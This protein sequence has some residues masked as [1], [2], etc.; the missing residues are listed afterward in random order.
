MPTEMLQPVILGI[1]QGLGE[2][3][4]ISS[5]AHLILVPY[6]FNWSDPGLAFDVALHFG[7]LIAVLA[8][9]WK[10]W[11]A[12]FESA[13]QIKLSP[14]NL[15]LSSY[16]YSQSMPGFLIIT[17]LP[18][19]LA[20]YFL[21]SLAETRFRNPLLI[22]VTLALFGL[23]LYLIDKY[24]P[25]DKDLSHLNIKNSI[26]VGICQAVAII[27]GIS[28]S[29]ATISASRFMG[30]NQESAARFSFLLS[31]PVILGAVIFKIEYLISAFS[32]PSL[33][34]AIIVSAISGYLAIKYLLKFIINYNYTVFFW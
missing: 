31:T 18:A 23:I 13:F 7:T 22:A 12:I 24:Y 30:F 2:F 21:E 32:Q 19:V 15:K 33:L 25:K 1:V 28:R 26:F 17:T 5:T 4:P 34:W 27:P 9:F 6:F 8:Y 29:G 11:L 16:N 14:K 3:L 20:G 10:D